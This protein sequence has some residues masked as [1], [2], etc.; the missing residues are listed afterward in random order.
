MCC[1][2]DND[3]VDDRANDNNKGRNNNKKTQGKFQQLLI[4][5]FDSLNFASL[6][7]RRYQKGS[8]DR[9]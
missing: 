9:R 3:A 8:N 7:H 2:G 1:C 4:F 5:L 6:V